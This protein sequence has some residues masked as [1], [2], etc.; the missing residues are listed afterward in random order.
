MQ[1]APLNS[2][3]FLLTGAT[4][5][6]GS[7]ILNALLD[8][9]GHVYC[10]RRRNS[11]TWRVANRESQIAWLCSETCDYERFF[12]TTPIDCVIHCATDYG[13]KSVHPLASIDANLALP[14]KLL[15]HAAQF[16][17]T[18]FINTDTVLDKDLNTY[19]L[20]KR[21]FSEWLL[22]YSRR[23][24]T[25]NIALQHFYGPDD[26]P[27]KFTSH[28]INSLI[29]NVE[30]L[31]LTLGAQQRDF[32]YIDDV[33]SAFKMIILEALHNPLR[34][35]FSRYE[36]GSGN[37][38]SIKDFVEACKRLASPCETKLDFGALPYRAG[39]LMST[40]TD[41]TALTS[42]GWRP[43]HSLSAGLSRTISVRRSRLLCAA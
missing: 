18:A 2:K 40:K 11:D 17:V 28:V 5:Y 6:L 4:G 20:S 25:T 23:I 38:I 13:R 43:E 7:H 42:L 41:L 35:G 30:R 32:I 29:S 27:T 31:K 16:G 39:E 15:H 19:S 9:G 26:D 34:A 3:T 14:L 10:T 21:Q 8:S 36:L 37:T 1:E 33:V 12:H 24:A 22:K